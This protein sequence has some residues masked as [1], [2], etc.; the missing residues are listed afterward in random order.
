MPIYVLFHE[1]AGLLLDMFLPSMHLQAFLLPPPP[2]TRYLKMPGI[3]MP[4]D[5]QQLNNP[6]FPNSRPYCYLDREEV[7]AVMNG[8]DCTILWNVGQISLFKA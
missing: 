4:D 5:G 1:L 3:Q 6:C 8:G 2:W 7:N